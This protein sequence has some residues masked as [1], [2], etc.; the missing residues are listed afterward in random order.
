VYACLHVCVCLCVCM[1]VF[2]C[3][4]VWVCACVI[5]NL[6]CSYRG[7]TNSIGRK[8]NLKNCAWIKKDSTSGRANLCVHGFVCVGVGV[9]VFARKENV[10]VCA[11]VCE[12]V[13][14]CVCVRV[15]CVC[16]CTVSIN[17]AQESDMIQIISRTHSAI[18]LSSTN[19]RKVDRMRIENPK[20]LTQKKN[21]IR[22]T[23]QIRFGDYYYYSGKH[24]FDTTA[25]GVCVCVCVCACVHV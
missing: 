20:A 1:C 9:R 7:D 2:V 8:V 14:M 17:I 15:L 24:M 6:H 16:K 4:G 10:C 5:L 13:C 21:P 25:T 3:A 19:H 22:N 18:S 12:C 23:S 11:N